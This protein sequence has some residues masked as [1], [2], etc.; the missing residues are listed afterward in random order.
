MWG[1]WDGSA[2]VRTHRTFKLVAIDGNDKGT[3]LDTM[4]FP[5]TGYLDGLRLGD[6]RLFTM[7]RSQ[8]KGER[9]FTLGIGGAKL[10]SSE[11]VVEEPNKTGG[12]YYWGNTY[13]A[14]VAGDRALL[15]KYDYNAP[16]LYL[17]DTTNVTTPTFDFV[18]ELGS[19]MSEARIEGDKA[20]CSL[21]VYGVQVLPLKK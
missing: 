14:D 21:D 1:G 12:Y 3:Q 10:T 5:T 9:A 6:A 18:G 17:L 4:P 19:Y 16:K 13:I 8:S 20:V 7:L 11:I 15:A 2:C